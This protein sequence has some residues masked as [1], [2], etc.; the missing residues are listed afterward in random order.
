MK[1]ITVEKIKINGIL[2]ILNILK[3]DFSIKANEHSR[4]ILHLDMEEGYQDILNSVIFEHKIVDIINK[5]NNELIFSGY[6]EEF[7]DDLLSNTNYATVKLVSST[8]DLDLVKKKRT[9]QNANSTFSSVINEVASSANA[10]INISIVDKAIEFPLVQYEETDWEFLKKIAG[11]IGKAIIPFPSYNG[12]CLEFG[13]KS[14]KS[15]VVNSNFCKY[16]ISDNYYKL[17]G[18]LSNYAKADFAYYVI[19]TYENFDIGDIVIFNGEKTFVSS[20]LGNLINGEMIF[21]YTIG[22]EVLNIQKRCESKY[23]SGLSIKGNVLKTKEDK[24]KVQLNTDSE[25]SSGSEYDFDWYPSLGKAL[26]CMPEI[27]Q[28]VNLLFWNC[29]C[30]K[31]SL[32]SCIYSD[33]SNCTDNNKKLFMYN[34]KSLELSKDKIELSVGDLVDKLF[35]LDLKN[36]T[37]NITSK[38][39]IKIKSNSKINISASVMNITA[40]QQIVIGNLEDTLNSICI[41]QTIEIN[42]KEIQTTAKARISFDPFKDGPVVCERNWMKLLEKLALAVLA[43]AVV[44]AVAAVAAAAIFATGGAAAVAMVGITATTM[45]GAAASAAIGVGVAAL[46]GGL[47]SAVISVGFQWKDDRK[48]G[49]KRDALDY[50]YMGLDQFCTGAVISAPMALPF[51]LLEQLFGVGFSSLYYQGVDQYL[52][53]KYGSDFYDKDGNVIITMLFDILGAGIAHGINKL[54]NKAFEKVCQKLVSLS[55]AETLKLAT[56]L[57]KYLGKNYDLSGA[58]RNTTKKAIRILF[59][60]GVSSAERS[61]ILKYLI[62]GGID[63]PGTVASDNNINFLLGD[64][65]EVITETVNEDEYSQD[66]EY[67]TYLKFDENNRLVY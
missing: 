61:K 46:I 65:N 21:E 67:K 48:K 26:Y 54:L 38:K 25:Q 8:I 51:G 50:L 40:P 33:T 32:D 37:I 49:I 28:T 12:I 14:K 44:A 20:K 24:I 47:A 31:A 62:L 34:N 64:L 16:G 1:A 19:K 52:D 59:N 5:S 9:F 17:G 56:L 41:N 35:N 60:D 66:R 2:N 55:K 42:G 43:V 30:N 36:N 45:G 3:V 6:I 53:D 4:A 15:R 63:A 23:L 39:P 29:E 57:N 22:K 7:E 27:G 18:A 13:M 58:G 10:L 11:R